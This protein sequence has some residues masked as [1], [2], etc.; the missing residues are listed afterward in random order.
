[1]DSFLEMLFYIS[2]LKEGL[3]KVNAINIPWDSRQYTNSSHI[4][5]CILCVFSFK[6]WL[7]KIHCVNLTICCLYQN[8]K[9]LIHCII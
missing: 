7:P 3:R 5:V 6:P 1:M 9:N 8:E 2:L 4:L